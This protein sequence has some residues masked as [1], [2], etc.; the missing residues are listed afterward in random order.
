MTLNGKVVIGLGGFLLTLSEGL[1]ALAESEIANTQ[2]TTCASGTVR[3]RLALSP[4][5]VHFWATLGEMDMCNAMEEI[6]I[7]QYVAKG[8]V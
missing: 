1:S 4:S 3:T 8:T 5:P 7:F 6:L 2:T